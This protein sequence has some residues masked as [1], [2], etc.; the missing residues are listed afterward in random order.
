MNRFMK[1]MS[2]LGLATA[3][4]ALTNGEP[5]PAFTA[6]NQDGKVIHL[7]DYRGKP[8]LIYFYPKDNTPVCTAEACSF[9]DRFSEIQN[10][11][12]V[13]LG[14][15]TQ[16]E[17]SHTQFKS[18]LHLPFDLVSDPDGKIGALYGVGTMPLIGLLQRKSVLIDK[19]GRV[20]KVYENVSAKTHTDEVLGDLKNL[21]KS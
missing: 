1:V 9:R 13:I 20:V 18:K 14:V 8:L 16:D 10:F 19:D 3:T 17:K 4:L 21:P 6:K 12:A 15:S 7:S 2:M 11:G 5:A